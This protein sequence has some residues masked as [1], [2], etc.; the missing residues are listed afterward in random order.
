MS[1][2]LDLL[3][4]YNFSFQKLKVKCKHTMMLIDC[5]IKSVVLHCQLKQ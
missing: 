4:S 1:S 2:Y 3:L 5:S